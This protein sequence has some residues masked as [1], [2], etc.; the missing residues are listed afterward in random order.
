MPVTKPTAVTRTPFATTLKDHMFVAASVVM[1]EMARTAQ[2][3]FL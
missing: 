3:N 2:V 1:L